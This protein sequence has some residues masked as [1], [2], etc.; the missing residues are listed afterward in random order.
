MSDIER[1][2]ECL[3]SGSCNCDLIDP[4]DFEDPAEARCTFCD[5][6]RAVLALIRESSAVAVAKERE[7]CAKLVEH[8]AEG[9]G[10]W[11]YI[12]DKI[13]ETPGE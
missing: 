13:R 3:S 5:E 6:V 7:R 9:S 1:V 8:E 4:D 10:G 12:A 2:L 11:E